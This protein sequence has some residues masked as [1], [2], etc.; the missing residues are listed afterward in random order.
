MRNPDVSVR[1][2]G[3][4]EKCTYCVQRINH[5]RIQAKIEDRS[6]QDGE[7]ITACEHACPT[8]AIVFGDK[9]DKES[10]V[11]KMRGSKRNYGMLNELNTIPRTTYLARLTNPHESLAVAKTDD[12]GGGHH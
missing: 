5:A 1:T 4:M 9:N 2:R 6:I 8:N 3:V 11:S 12:H 7:I 10:R